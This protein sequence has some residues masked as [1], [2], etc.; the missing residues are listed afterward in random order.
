MT[1]WTNSNDITEPINKMNLENQTNSWFLG[2]RA[3]KSHFIYFLPFELDF[4]FLSKFSKM[5]AVCTYL[6]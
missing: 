6:P 5:I 4:L 1:K 3:K 2:N